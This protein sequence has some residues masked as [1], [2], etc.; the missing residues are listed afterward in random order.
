MRPL[1]WPYIV[2]S[3]YMDYI[4]MYCALQ[5]GCHKETHSVPLVVDVPVIIDRPGKLHDNLPAKCSMQIQIN[6]YCVSK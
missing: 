6:I 5:V 4:L 1:L 2:S 3:M